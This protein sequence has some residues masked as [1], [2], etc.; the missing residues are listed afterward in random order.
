MGTN[1]TMSPECGIA[2]VH[3]L[4]TVATT[5]MACQVLWGHT[6]SGGATGGAQAS[7]APLNNSTFWHT[8]S[9]VIM[10]MHLAIT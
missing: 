4:A 10:S 7:K 6:A 1:V 8:S 5:Y 9:T 2:A 3:R